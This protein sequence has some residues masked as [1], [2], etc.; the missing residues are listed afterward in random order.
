MASIPK[1]PL[2]RN[3]PEVNRIGF[4]CM[5][6]SAF[7][8]PPKPDNER[9]A[10]LDAAYEAGEHFWDSAD[11]YMDNE[12]L[13]GKWFA[14]HPEKRKDIFL[15]T[16]FA[17]HP[18][19]DGSLEIRG[20]PEY[21]KE[22]CAKSLKRLGLPY[23]D[24]YYCHRL[25][26]NVPVEKTV[27][28]MAELKKEGKIKY[29]G[30]SECSAESLRRA[31]KVH[32][33]TAVQI[34][35]SPFTLDIEDPRVKLL[36]TCRELGVAVVAYSPL[37]R[38]MLTGKYRSPNDFPEG[39]WRRM[40]PRFSE[41][42][43]PK[44]LQLVDEIQSLARKKGCTAGQLTLAWLLAQGEDIFPIPG[45]THIERLKEN[46][47]AVNV[48]LN[49]EDVDIIR[50]AC[51]NAEVHGERYPAQMADHLFADTPAL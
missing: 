44:N 46:I 16:K 40:A 30:L 51:K 1:A 4:G 20:D 38:G 47:G 23:V 19:P 34:E 6:L 42:N 15:A 18:K 31:Y 8:G 17:L 9:F 28:A 12:D 22:A 13:L 21:V 35:Y 11:I 50:K 25:D 41:E 24:L 36:E 27:Q 7:Y 26:K 33:I 29:L 32:P 3:G 2:G 48:H 43:F 10:V 49:K 45:T 14:A 37:G 5:G 39:D